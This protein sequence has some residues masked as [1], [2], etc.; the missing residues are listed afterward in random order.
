MRRLIHQHPMMKLRTKLRLVPTVAIVLAA[1]AGIT[2]SAAAQNAQTLLD[3]RSLNGWQ[4][5]GA[6]R[7]VVEQDGGIVGEGGP[8]LLVYTG[9]T[10]GNFVLDLDYRADSPGAR[11][12]IVVRVPEQ[13]KTRDDALKAGYAVAIG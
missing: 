4:Q 8:G 13:P 6:G 11:A 9:R 1:N 7:F 2:T 5:I 3:G 10:F 12:G